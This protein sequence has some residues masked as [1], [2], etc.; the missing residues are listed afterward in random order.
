MSA[1]LAAAN[2]P[3]S[4][5]PAGY[6]YRFCSDER[7]G[8]LG[9]CHRFDEGDSYREVV[10]N[11]AEQY[12]RQYIFTNFRRY[13]S[14]FE[15]GPYI[16]DRLIGRHFTILQDIFQNLLCSAIRSIPEFRDRVTSDF[17]FYD[18]FMASADVLNFYARILGQP[19]I[20]SYALNP[21]SGN[22][23][24]FSST[25]RTPSAPS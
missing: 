12:E 11:L 6:G 20:G 24:R 25:P 19:D 23:E 16:F 17:G 3:R 22:F 7:V 15:I 1:A 8:T 14:D 18:Q 2:N 10:R 9:W 13:R 5:V 21:A 4:S